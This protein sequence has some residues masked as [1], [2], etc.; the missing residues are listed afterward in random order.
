M[1]QRTEKGNPTTLASVSG[2][3]KIVKCMR[4]L[5]VDCEK[6]MTGVIIG[7]LAREKGG[8]FEAKSLMLRY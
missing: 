3:S 2:Y 5:C 8:F 4:P 7:I 1:V 6:A